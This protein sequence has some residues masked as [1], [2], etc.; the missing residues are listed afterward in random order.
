MG[1]GSFPAPDHEYPAYLELRLTARDSAGLTDTRSIRLDP[2][3]VPLSFRSSPSGL[4]LAVD[5]ATSTTPFE[6]TVIQ[7]SAN[8]V[9]AP[10]TQTLG[11]DTFGFDSWSDG[12]AL[13]H[14][15]TAG[16]A[17]TYTATYSRR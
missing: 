12:G 6:R 15:V 14:D 9:S 11:P 7:G 2:R 16:A 13:T 10:A 1:Q 3:T 17:A 8:T 4:R 5:G